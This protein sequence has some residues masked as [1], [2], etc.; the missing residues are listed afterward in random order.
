MKT[1][2]TE[3]KIVGQPTLDPNVC[4]FIVSQSILPDGT[5]ICRN[6]EMAEGSPLFEALFAIDGIRE[7]L[8]TGNALTI[9]KETLDGWPE[10]GKKIGHAIR[11]T[12]NSGKPLID[13]NIKKKLPSEEKIRET[14]EKLFEEEVNPSIASHGGRVELADVE[15]TKIYLR[16]GGGCQG[17]SSATVT[18]RQ[19][20]EKAIRAALPDITEIHDIT[21]HNSGANPYYR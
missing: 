1:E 13:I 15:G 4:K 6:R 18:L 3:I 10:M 16:L 11:E 14:I 12:I 7:I 19:G 8:A 20:I 5:V 17:C 9:A 2:T 21:D